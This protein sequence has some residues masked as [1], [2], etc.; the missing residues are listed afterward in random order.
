MK[1][2]EKARAEGTS[3]TLSIQYSNNPYLQST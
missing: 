1:L 3:L 2:K